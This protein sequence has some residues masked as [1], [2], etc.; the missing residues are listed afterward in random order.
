MATYWQTSLLDGNAGSKAA[1]G[2]VGV[3]KVQRSA[4][5]A[6]DVG[7][8]VHVKGTL[9]MASGVNFAV[10]DVVEAAILPA[11]HVPVDFII[12][13]DQFDSNAA[14]LLTLSVG[15]M[16]GSV[17]DTSRTTANFSGT[18]EG[19]AAIPFGKG[20]VA[21]PQ[22]LRNGVFATF[23]NFGFL[24]NRIASSSTTDRSIG[25]FIAAAAATNPATV[26]RLDFELIYR[27]ASYGG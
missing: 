23:L 13:G 9:Q 18:P 7:T 8:L 27:V 2:S 11:D 19:G 17:G 10:N 24:W 12:S 14:P 21:S 5:I 15:L 26:R 3:S 25:F 4:P 20:V 16:T 22:Y 1:I 6:D